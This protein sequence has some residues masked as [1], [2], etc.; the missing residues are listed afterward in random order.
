MSGATTRGIIL[1]A[2]FTWIIR[3]IL[4]WPKKKEESLTSPLF[5]SVNDEK[6]K[7]TLKIKENQLWSP[8]TM[9]LFLC[10]AKS[11]TIKQPVTARF[12]I[13]V[14][15]EKLGKMLCEKK[16]NPVPF[17]TGFTSSE[18]RFTIGTRAKILKIPS[19]S[20]RAIVEYE[21]EQLV[22]QNTHISNAVSLLDSE[23][24]HP[25]CWREDFNSLF[26]N[27][28]SNSDI[29]FIV[30]GQEI[31]A[32]KLI[33]SA[34]SPVFA[35]MFRSD[36]KKKVMDRIDLPDVSP[37]IFNE[38][39]HFIYTDR[40]ELTESNVTPLLAAA[41][42]Y[43][44]PLLKFK[45]EE[46]IIKN[47]SIENCTEMMTLADLHNALN[48]KKMTEDYFRSH[49]TEIRKTES[50]KALKKFHP[51]IAFNIVERLLDVE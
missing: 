44:L 43:L 34:R 30:A 33:L 2:E 42:N 24:D 35:A 48:L 41:D 4:K 8:D 45:C 3:N 12:Y 28:Q 10:L 14:W 16:S 5:H 18:G 37:D 26:T 9:E 7:W 1:K 6:T 15:E 25:N 47:L 29:G 49:H 20:I 17:I 50:W 39:L 21:K 13:T 51:D 19:I 40:V 36:L 27:Q 38:F 23:N 31:K 11:A 46:F 32:H 22:E